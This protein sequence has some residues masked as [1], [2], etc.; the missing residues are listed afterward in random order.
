MPDRYPDP[1][2]VDGMTPSVDQL[3]AWLHAHKGD[4]D[5]RVA[6]HM[7]LGMLADEQRAHA[8]TRAGAHGLYRKAARYRLAWLS[9][10]ARARGIH[11]AALRFA[12]EVR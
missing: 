10:A 9:A 11:R 2:W 3:R 1:T 4:H 8:V 5:A 6:A 12:R 7:I